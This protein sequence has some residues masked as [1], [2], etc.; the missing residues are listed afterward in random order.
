LWWNLR[1]GPRRCSSVRDLTH[2]RSRSLLHIFIHPLAIVG[3]SADPHM[4]RPE[5]CLVC[6]THQRNGRSAD[7]HISGS[8]V[9]K[10]QQDLTASPTSPDNKY[11]RAW[12]QGVA[13]PEYAQV[14]QILFRFQ[15]QFAEFDARGSQTPHPHLNGHKICCH[16]SRR[17]YTT[18]SGSPG[19]AYVSS[20]QMVWGLGGMDEL[21]G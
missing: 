8:G 7:A 1:N 3:L 4:R 10:A 6:L 9:A 13:G 16:N 20:N 14:S 17:H 5:S 11:R 2:S 12:Y 19:N 21:F 15:M 18:E